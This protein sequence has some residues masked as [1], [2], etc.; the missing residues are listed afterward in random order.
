MK[1]EIYFKKLPDSL[2]EHR[3]RL[4]TL[5][6]LLDKA[7]EKKDL[8]IIKRLLDDSKE[9]NYNVQVYEQIY[10]YLYDNFNLYSCSCSSTNKEDK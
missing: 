9:K 2:T 1:K 6:Y 5:D 4:H 3:K 7:A 8:K 10:D